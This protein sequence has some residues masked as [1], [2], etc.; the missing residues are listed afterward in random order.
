MTEMSLLSSPAQRGRMALRRTTDVLNQ[1]MPDY[2]TTMDEYTGP[3][4]IMT[5]LDFRHT[6]E[7]DIAEMVNREQS[8]P[9]GAQMP[10]G[11]A[12]EVPDQPRPEDRP[13][14]LEETAEIR[15]HSRENGAGHLPG[16]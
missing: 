14:K 5:D 3:I 13:D 16:G 8:L 7:P 15:M 2:V 12:H 9:P 10:A 6:G 1:I 11:S 4:R